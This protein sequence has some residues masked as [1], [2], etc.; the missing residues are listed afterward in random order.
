VQLTQ[1]LA[2]IGLQTGLGEWH[3]NCCAADHKLLVVRDGSYVEVVFLV[4]VEVFFVW[5]IYHEP[6]IRIPTAN[7]CQNQKRKMSH[8]PLL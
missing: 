8:K 7:T 5:E 2:Y 4:R 1:T 3:L 6:H